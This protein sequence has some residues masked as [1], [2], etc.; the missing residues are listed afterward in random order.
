MSQNCKTWGRQSCL[1][2]DFR[3]G[4]PVENTEAGSVCVF[5]FDNNRRAY[6]QYRNITLV[7]NGGNS[8]YDALQFEAERKFSQGLYF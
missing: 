8:I 1:Q 6:P 7:D 4:F 3:A 5:P 2:A